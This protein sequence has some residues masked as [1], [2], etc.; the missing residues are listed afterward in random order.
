MRGRTLQACS[1][2]AATSCGVRRRARAV[3]EPDLPA[4]GS[5]AD[6]ARSRQQRS[7]ARRSN[8][9]APRTR[10][11]ASNSRS[12]GWSRKRA[13]WAAKVPASSRS[14]AIR[15][16][17]AAGSTGRST[18]SAMRSSA[19]RIELE[20]LNGGTTER[21]AQRQSLLIA[22]GDNGCGPQ[23][24]SAALAGQQGGFFDRL[25]GGNG[26]MFSAP[27]GQ[28]GGTFRT[29][30]VRTC[31][32]FYYPDFVRDLVGSLPRRRTDLPAHVPGG[33][34]F[35]LHLSQSRRG[36]G[37][38]GFAQRPAL[39]PN[40]RPR[41]TTARRSIRRAAAAGRAKA[42]PRRSRST[43][44]TTRSRP[45]TSSSPSRTPSGCR[46][47]ALAPTAS[48]SVPIRARRRTAA[49]ATGTDRGSAGRNRSGQAD[50]AHGRTDIPAGALIR[51][52]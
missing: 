51:L 31:D 16:R 42:G 50:R 3:A 45:A 5:P 2:A 8:P 12:T 23:Y 29:I 34:S 28:M 39:L 1:D 47:R 15:R 10:S 36:S 21:A 14:S 48:R 9:R 35:A 20:Q 46:S 17:N 32:G 22:L 4:A 18:S 7:G 33:G 44:P 25:F 43:E 27:S 37:A 19:C 30:C 52:Q 40:C 11:T 6:F 49:A 24:R 41:S 26:G 13:A 38:G